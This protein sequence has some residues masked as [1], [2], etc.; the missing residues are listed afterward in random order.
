MD[1][2]LDITQV[3]NVLEI[4]IR[5]LKRYKDIIQNSKND[6]AHVSLIKWTLTYRSYLTLQSC[7]LV[8]SDVFALRNVSIIFKKHIFYIADN[9]IQVFVLAKNDKK[10]IDESHRL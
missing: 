8:T 3:I 5:E 4:G 6:I 2:D 9:I 7:A 1:I 10:K